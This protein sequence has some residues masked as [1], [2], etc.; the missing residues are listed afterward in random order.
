MR[1]RSV[2]ALCCS[3]RLVISLV[4]LITGTLPA[5]CQVGI[6]RAS[7]W[8]TL[9][10]SYAPKL[11]H[12]Y[13]WGVDGTI[14]ITSDFGFLVGIGP[15]YTHYAYREDP[16]LYK[17]GLVGAIAM[18]SWRWKIIYSFFMP[19]V[20]DRLAFE[21]KSG[22]ST[23]EVINFYGFG[24]DTPRDMA[25]EVTGYYDVDATV[26]ATVAY[27][28]YGLSPSLW[29]G[30]ALGLNY[31]NMRN[32]EGRLIGE[33][34]P[35]LVGTNRLYLGPGIQL[36][37][38]TREPS[39]YPRSGTYFFTA[40]HNWFATVP[41]R[42]PF[43]QAAAD[44]RWYGMVTRIPDVVLALRLTGFATFGEVPFYQAARLGGRRNVR[45]YEFERF[46]G[47]HMIAGSADLRFPFFKD[48][49]VIPVEFG[50]FLMA[51]EGRLWY[52]GA[53][54]GGWRGSWG[55]GIW[56]ATLSRDVLG[57]LY[58]AFCRE[59]SIVRAGFGFDY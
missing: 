40:A 51:D 19:S 4:L 57:I 59:S 9:G 52:E 37:S 27:M 11:D 5:P 45:G 38:D 6:D 34:D 44:F 54:P 48:V 41:G 25:K 18:P 3:K 49:I 43:Y 12:G 46:R 30:P 16:Y 35:V 17:T 56:G 20:G 33:L 26:Y 55:F 31:M 15:T 32:A 21:L 42:K 23:V 29:V 2:Y 1:L 53:S 14:D 10:K 39:L 58:I 47:D 8:M 24:S 50:G 36:F 13:S 22:I 28:G 7:Q